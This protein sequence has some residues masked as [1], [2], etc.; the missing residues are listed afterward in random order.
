MAVRLSQTSTGYETLRGEDLRGKVER[1]SQIPIPSS[2]GDVSL[3]GSVKSV[4]GC[5][6]NTEPNRSS[7]ERS[8]KRHE[9]RKPQSLVRTVNKPRPD[10]QPKNPRTRSNS[11]PELIMDVDGV[12]E[13]RRRRHTAVHQSLP[14]V[15][16]SP[17]GIIYVDEF[18]ARAAFTPSVPPKAAILARVIPGVS[19]AHQKDNAEA[20]KVVRAF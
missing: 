11:S 9:P 18:T 7:G 14:T 17:P 10:P 20:Q 16:S 19:E 13:G 8:M 3:P 12:D 6:S 2:N 5:S 15:P 1:A 4:H